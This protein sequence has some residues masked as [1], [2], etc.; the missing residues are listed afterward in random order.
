M[1]FYFDT[2]S[3]IKLYVEEEGSEAVRELLAAADLGASSVVLYV[4]MRAALA[5]IYQSARLDTAS[6]RKALKSFETDWSNLATVSLTDPILRLAADLAERHLLK[7]LDAI[8]LAS[9]LSL[10]RHQPLTV[11]AWDRPLLDAAIAE[12]L[13]TVPTS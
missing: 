7:A 13:P 6:Y 8:H 3:L 9:A 2:S 12:G 4:E 1:I 11:S 10:S 5:R